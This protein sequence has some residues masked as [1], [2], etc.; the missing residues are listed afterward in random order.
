LEQLLGALATRGQKRVGELELLTEGE[1]RQVL[2]EWN[3][4]AAE[5]PNVRGIQQLFEAQVELSPNAV[6][7][8]HEGDRITYEELNRRANQ[9]AHHLR[10]LVGPEVLVAVCM[11][12][13][14]ETIV[15]LLGV[16]KAGGAYVPLDPL[17]PQERLHF[18]LEDTAAPVLLTQQHLIELFPPHDAKV[19]CLDTQWTEVVS[20]PD[21]NP[22]PNANAG[23]LAYVIYTSGSTGTPKGVA[24]E[25]RSTLTFLHWAKQTFRREQMEGVL[26][27]T[28]ICFDL[29]I[30]EIFGTLSAGGKVIL[31]ED[32]LALASLAAAGE[33]TLINTVP[34]AIAELVR[35]KAIPS[36]VRTINLAGEALKN[37]LVQE[38]YKQE[39]IREVY[40]LYGPSEDTTYSTFT[41]VEKGQ[42]DAVSIGRPVANTQVYL[43]D[44]HLRPVPVGVAGE[45]YLGGEGLARC[46]LNRPDLTAERFISNPFNNAFGACLYKTGDR[47]RY[48]SDGNIEYLGRLDQQVKVRGYRIELGEIEAVLSQHPDVRESV[49]LAREDTTGNQQLVAY[50]VTKAQVPSVS[51][52]HGFLKARLPAYMATLAFVF[53]NELPLT[54]NG[55]LD[56]KA[57]PAATHIRDSNAEEHLAPR[58]AIEDLVIGIWS[59]VLK[60]ETIVRED[61]FFE[62]GGHSLLGTQV[63]SR[64]KEVFSVELPLRILFERPTVR[65][66]SEAIEALLRGSEVATAP[67]L[68]RVSRDRA[69]PLSFGQQRLWFLDKLEPDS[70]FYNL[71]RAVRF[72]GELNVQA[73]ERAFNEVVQ[74]HE[75][76]RTT[77]Q[78]NGD[79]VV[80]IIHSP[81]QVR[82]PVEEVS[83]HSRPEREAETARLAFEESHAP[84][85]LTNG[86][87]LRFRLLRVDE[88]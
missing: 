16:L 46:Y 60:V 28:S 85:D 24:I 42:D 67:A 45:L 86:P 88:D 20:Q 6:A 29:S 27:S 61:N 75:S 39:T 41:K 54:P 8:V 82:L 30:F 43:L 44:Q 3:R 40:N 32:A 23:N 37:S 1:R 7:I 51:E 79:E 12:R 18:M 25:H 76:L 4:T 80:Q 55:K 84:F 65:E 81:Q 64:I 77:F 10:G 36:S 69:I 14:I 83:G 74:R 87:L 47:A 17:Y 52:L 63:V 9:L 26:A 50:V 33:V 66:V 11:E 59:D 73:L 48:R 22:N 21:Q 58:T 13:S 15:A 57:L 72:S 38:I 62:L 2:V 71:H 53:M 34:S 5:Y 78:N 19:I 56:R 49:V 31:V 35:L 68:E 70:P